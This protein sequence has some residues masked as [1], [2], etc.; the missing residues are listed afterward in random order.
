[1]NEFALI[2]T[3]FKRLSDR[4]GALLSAREPELPADLGI[5]D[6]CALMR[7][8]DGM[9]LAVSSDTLVAGVHFPGQATPFD[10]GYK[11][12]AVNLSDLAAMGATPAWFSLCV[13][14]QD[15]SEDWITAFCEGMAAVTQGSP[16]QLV[17]GDTTRG[18]LS[19]CVQVMG[20]VPAGQALTRSGARPGGEVDV[21]GCVGEAALGLALALDPQAAQWQQA[22]D[23]P[24]LLARLHRPTPRVALGQALRGIASACIDVSDGLLADLNHVLRASQVGAELELDLIPVAAGQDRMISITAGDDYE[25]CFTAPAHARSQVIALAQSLSLPVSMIGCISK[26]QGLRDQDN[27]ALTPAGYQHF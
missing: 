1:M 2:E 27:Q 18:P 3:H 17:G 15:Q 9:Q 13:T 26:A 6:D 12:L 7:V 14:L 22:L 23:H 19:I 24:H 5:G 10:I 25:L 11:A 4:T 21:S 8:P 20:V 16:I